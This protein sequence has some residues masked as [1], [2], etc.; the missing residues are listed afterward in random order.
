M[1]DSPNPVAEE[2][3]KSA[4]ALGWIEGVANIE[5][6]LLISVRMLN[7]SEYWGN[8]FGSTYLASTLSVA[9]DLLGWQSLV[10]RY[11]Q[12]ALQY[13]QYTDPLRP[14]FQLEWSRAL[15][16]N[17]HADF[18]KS[19]DHARRAAKVAQST[20]DLRSWGAAMDQ[21]SWAHL[22]EGRLVEALKTSQ[23]MIKVAEEGSDLQV[24]YWG[25]LGRGVT[26]KRLGKIDEAISDL[27]Q[28]VE[29]SEKVPDY[30]TQV[31]ASGWLGRCYTANGELAQSLTR[32]EASQEILSNQ[33]QPAILMQKA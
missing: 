30:H 26:K 33:R 5:R 7:A 2:L 11:Y 27:K 8:A 20:G 18:E 6:L 4:D 29:V 16:Y 13:S 15:H 21:S 9:F 23:E 10:E 19:L 24:L 17:I 14:R 25:L 12:L 1:S 3:F 28:A 32:L 22:S 31:A